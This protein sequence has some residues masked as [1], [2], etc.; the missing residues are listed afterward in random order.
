MKGTGALAERWKY[1]SAEKRLLG[2]P[3]RSERSEVRVRGL[4]YENRVENKGTY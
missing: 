1:S 3:D 4:I 2:R